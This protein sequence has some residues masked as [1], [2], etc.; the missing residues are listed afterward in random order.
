METIKK[1]H[2]GAMIR[3]FI[4]KN[5]VSR[6]NTARKMGLPNTVFY[7]YENRASLHTSNL[8]RICDAFQYNFF[9]DV[10]NALP[11]SYAFDKTLRTS[12]D[13][14]I[15]EQKAEIMKLKFE[16]DLMRDLLKK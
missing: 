11:E 14:I 2:I 15:E 5:N 10:A 9:M 6:T 8:M 3:A 4:I 1:V 7:A 13:F 12:K 16:N